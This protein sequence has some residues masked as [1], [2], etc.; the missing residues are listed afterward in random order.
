[1]IL[2]YTVRRLRIWKTL[3]RARSR[4]GGIGG[5]MLCVSFSGV[6]SRPAWSCTSLHRSPLDQNQLTIWSLNT[7]DR[8]PNACDYTETFAEFSVINVVGF[9]NNFFSRHFTSIIFL[10]CL[11]KITLYTNA[12]P[13]SITT[14]PPPPLRLQAFEQLW[15]LNWIKGVAE[16]HVLYI[17]YLYVHRIY[18]RI[19]TYK[20]VYFQESLSFKLKRRP[21]SFRF[22]ELGHCIC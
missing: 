1:M 20:F 15:P 12:R 22:V 13:N 9:I 16:I 11:W 10:F 21:G 6:I 7:N 14:P 4:R 17:I 8:R 2:L 18:I 5:E 19:Y 3:S